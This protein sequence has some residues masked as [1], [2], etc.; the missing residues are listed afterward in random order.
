MA[1][2]NGNGDARADH[3]REIERL[4]AKQLIV[5]G[6][7][8]QEVRRMRASDRRRAVER[9]AGAPWIHPPMRVAGVARSGAAPGT[10]GSKA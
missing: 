9:S 1:C 2:E 6:D 10:G 5:E 8:S 3:E 7:F 4:H